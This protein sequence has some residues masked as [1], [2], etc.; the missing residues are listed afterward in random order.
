M[1]ELNSLTKRFVCT[2][3][4]FAGNFQI[5]NMATI[6]N[7]SL[8]LPEKK[9]SALIGGNGAGKTTLFNLISGLIKPDK[10]E[11]YLSKKNHLV[12]LT[13]LKPH[14]IAQKGL[15]RMFQDN[16]IFK[17]MTIL[18]NMFVSSFSRF[19]EN[20]LESIF[21]TSRVRKTDA[22]RIEKAEAI[23]HELFGAKNKFWLKKN[24]LAGTLSYGQQRLLG[25]ARLFMGNFDLFLLDEP[26]SGINPVFVEQIEMIIKKM[27]VEKNKTVFLIEHDIDFVM[28]VADIC[29]YMERGQIAVE[30]PTIKVLSNQMV[31]EMY[32]GRENFVIG[33]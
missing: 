9:I 29:F 8:K 22:Q 1:L 17:D 3:K 15:G 21:R 16:H 13:S 33:S 28:K 23:F 4:K 5:D 25:L 26:T 32:L 31:N 30:G 10:G 20:P 24:N 18:E 7:L 19:G 27:V 12:K 6:N 2:E 11:I 14:Q